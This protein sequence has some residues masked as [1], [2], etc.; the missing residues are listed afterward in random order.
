MKLSCSDL[1]RR[2][3]RP[4]KALRL[5]RHVRP[6]GRLYSSPRPRFRNRYSP[7][8]IALLPSFAYFSTVRARRYAA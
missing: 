7:A 4:N 8:R 5:T 1:W 6:D 2:R 3:R